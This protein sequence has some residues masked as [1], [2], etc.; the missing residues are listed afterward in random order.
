MA[1]KEIY[2]FVFCL[3]VTSANVPSIATLS[4]SFPIQEEPNILKQAYLNILKG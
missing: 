3:L 1:S 4:K 2:L